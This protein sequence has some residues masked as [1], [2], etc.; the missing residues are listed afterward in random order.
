M[1]KRSTLRASDDDRERVADRL[2]HAAGEGR[3]VAEELEER[4]ERA[5]SARTYGQLSVLVADLPAPRDRRVGHALPLWVR[6]SLA[7]TLVL[8]VLAAVAVAAALLVALLCLWATWV[9]I[10][11]SA[12][13]RRRNLPRLDHAR[14]LASAA[15]HARSA[16]GIAR[17]GRTAL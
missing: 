6:A 3:L 13:G 14:V 15:R 10:S 16:A 7:V 4:L 2:R 17:S 5:F 9:V 8:G 12:F 1:A 11:W